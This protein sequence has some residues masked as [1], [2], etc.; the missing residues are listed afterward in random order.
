MGGQVP[1]GAALPSQ[2]SDRTDASETATDAAA[3]SLH[4]RHLLVSARQT[5]SELLQVPD[6]AP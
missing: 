1:A 5:K 4:A 3:A 2:R 6:T